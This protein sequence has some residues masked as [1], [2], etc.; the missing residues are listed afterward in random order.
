MRRGCGGA[1]LAPRRARWSGVAPFATFLQRGRRGTLEA[2]P[3]GPPPER[4]GQ[5][6]SAH[7]RPARRKEIA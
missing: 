5:G 2:T 3:E 7:C 1:A 4:A 6:R